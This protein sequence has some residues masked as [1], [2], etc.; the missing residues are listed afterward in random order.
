[1]LNPTRPLPAQ[2]FPGHVTGSH[3]FRLFPSI[4]LGLSTQNDLD[5]KL[6]ITR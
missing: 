2:Y 3:E 1:M 5:P 4:S 6:I